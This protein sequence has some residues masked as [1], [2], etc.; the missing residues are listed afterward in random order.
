MR[1]AIQTLTGGGVA[2]GDEQSEKEIRKL[3]MEE[4]ALGD[5]RFTEEMTKAKKTL[6]DTGAI[7]ITVTNGDETPESE[8][9]MIGTWSIRLEELSTSQ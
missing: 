4:L 9:D 7:K 5:T 3:V 2:G 6:Q 1:G 8:Q